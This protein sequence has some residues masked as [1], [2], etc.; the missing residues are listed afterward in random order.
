MCEQET[1]SKIANY[2]TANKVMNTSIHKQIKCVNLFDEQ[3]VSTQS[4]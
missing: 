3:N 4:S 2:F 1:V